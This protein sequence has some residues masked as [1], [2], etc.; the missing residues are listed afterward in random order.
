MRVTVGRSNAHHPGAPDA[1]RGKQGTAL[2][3]ELRQDEVAAILAKGSL[4]DGHV[5]Y[6]VTALRKHMETGRQPVRR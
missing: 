2:T 6:L 3:W 5:D 4:E 1:Q